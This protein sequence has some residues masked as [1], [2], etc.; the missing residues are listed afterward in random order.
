MGHERQVLLP[1]HHSPDPFRVGRR[2]RRRRRARAVVAD[3]RICGDA[4]MV[5]RRVCVV[6]VRR[7]VVLV[8]VL[9]IV[10]KSVMTM[11]VA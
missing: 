3:A 2:V 5:V 1:L 10:G 7:V 11:G 9:S 8:R 6:N 4:D